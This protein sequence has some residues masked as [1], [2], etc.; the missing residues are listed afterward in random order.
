M[1]LPLIYLEIMR[2]VLTLHMIE[3]LFDTQLKNNGKNGVFKH[4]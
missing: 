3:N 2:T 4:V 1:S